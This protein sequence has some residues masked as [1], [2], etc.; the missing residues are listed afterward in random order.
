MWGLRIV[1]ERAGWKE[2]KNGDRL[3]AVHDGKRPDAIA[4]SPDGIRTAIDCERTMKT[5]KR[6]EVILAHYLQSLRRGELARVVWLCPD[7]DMAARLR[8]IV[9][10][11]RT[12]PVAGQRVAVDPQR[13]HSLLH[14]L[15]FDEWPI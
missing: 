10:G 9:T 5:T 13:H 3:G 15:A 8:R 1:A 14:F 11:I 2:W 4:V 7:A 6:Y 12:V